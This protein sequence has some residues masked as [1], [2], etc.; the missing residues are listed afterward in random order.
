MV[1][2]ARKPSL[3][4][5]NEVDTNLSQAIQVKVEQARISCATQGEY[6]VEC[7]DAWDAV[8]ELSSA[9]G[10][11]QLKHSN[12]FDSYCEE[13]PDASACRIYDV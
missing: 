13:R 6:S 3:A 10:R 8:E 2:Y 11:Q 9:A 7:I 4:S 1:G 12:Y 5:T